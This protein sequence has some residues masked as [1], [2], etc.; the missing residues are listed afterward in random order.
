MK[1]QTQKGGGLAALREAAR[2]FN[3]LE[4]ALLHNQGSKKKRR[5]SSDK[6]RSKNRVAYPVLHWPREVNIMH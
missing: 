5:P 2:R 1:N 6:H 3:D 4:L